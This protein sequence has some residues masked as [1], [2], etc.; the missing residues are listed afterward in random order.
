M[1]TNERRQ[2][3]LDIVNSKGFATVDELSRLLFTSPSSIRRD[4]TVMQNN[5]LVKRTH[6]GVSAQDIVLGVASFYDRTKKNTNEKRIIA[7]KAA[8]LL[9]NGQKILLD[10]SSSAGFLLPFIAKLKNATVFTNNIAT[11]LRAIE[12]GIDTHCLGGHSVGGSASLAGLE[13]YSAISGINA[14]IL[15]FSS[16]SLDKNGVISDSTEEETYA[17]KLMLKAAKTRVFLCDSDKFDSLSTFIL[18]NI[19]DI[20][21]TV[22]DKEY[23]GLITKTKW[24]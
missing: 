17:R 24:L 10:S 11:A 14:D 9:C 16:Q 15:F 21:F 8:T 2:K 6:G 1:S 12:L 4:L 19:V 23:A 3:I 7:K 18:A 22:S 20:D 5:G 13:T